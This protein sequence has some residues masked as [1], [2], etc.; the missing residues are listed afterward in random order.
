VALAADDAQASQVR[1]L[2]ADLGAESVDAA[3]D[4]WWIGLRDAEEAEYTRQG[5]DFRK[6]ENLYR[7]GFD[8]AARLHDMAPPF[9]EARE[10]LRERRGLLVDEPA[11]RAGYERSRAQRSR[12]AA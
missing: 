1:Q 4:E 5:G 9:D 11:F 7:L 6:D 10:V 3:R 2:F 12:G 8:A